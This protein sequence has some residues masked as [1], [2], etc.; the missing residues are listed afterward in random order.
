M[1]GFTVRTID[2]AKEYTVEELY[3]A[4]KDHEFSAGEPKYYKDGLVQLII[5]PELDRFNQVRI[6][7]AQVK[8]APYSK[9]SI[10]KRDRVGIR[11][12]VDTYVLSRRTYG[13][14]GLFS[15]LGRNVHKAEKQVVSVYEELKT[16]EL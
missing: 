15:F 7:P 2:T 11:S 6:A 3:E 8:K 12:K 13:V 4:I 10:C 5:F 14:G 9:F 1:F 16:L